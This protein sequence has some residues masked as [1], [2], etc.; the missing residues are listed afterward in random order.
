M[1]SEGRRSET[2]VGREFVLE[3]A[4]TADFALVKAWKADTKGNL[5]FR[6]ASSNYN[7][8]MCKAARVT[9]AERGRRRHPAGERARRLALRRQGGQ[10]PQVRKED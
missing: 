6:K 10:V 5:I 4:I 3:E 8:A 7:S 9:V 2:F 1:R